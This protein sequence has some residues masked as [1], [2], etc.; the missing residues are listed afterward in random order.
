MPWTRACSFSDSSPGIAKPDRSPLMSAANTGMPA[1]EICSA[2]S[3]SVFV[4]PVPVAPATRPCRF[5]IE[6][7][8]LIGTPGTGL[9][10]AISTPSWMDGDEN[11]CPALIVSM[12]CWLGAI[13][14]PLLV[15]PRPG[16]G[17]HGLAWHNYCG[18]CD[19]QAR[20]DDRPYPEHGYAQRQWSA[21]APEQ[22]QLAELVTTKRMLD[23]EAV[24]E[25]DS[26]FYGDLF[27]HVVRWRG[28]LYRGR[29]ASCAAGRL[30]AASIRARA[31]AR[32]GRRREP[33]GW[34]PISTVKDDDE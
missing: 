21:I 26:T 9:P 30:A 3:C 27:A 2:I 18:L 11:V 4:L 29:P 31:S 10:S 25:E 24:L 23:L 33:V 20:G 17:S 1:L 7:D 8:R 6:Y 32:S 14:A 15:S 16:V 13:S 22:V 28:E 19:L 34:R 12:D 5:S